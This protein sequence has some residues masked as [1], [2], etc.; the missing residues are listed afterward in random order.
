MNLNKEFEVLY[1]LS[2]HWSVYMGGNEIITPQELN[3]LWERSPSVVPREPNKETRSNCVRG[4]GK[5]PRLLSFI[6]SIFS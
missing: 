5:Q 4:T 3:T 2:N 6:E 1:C